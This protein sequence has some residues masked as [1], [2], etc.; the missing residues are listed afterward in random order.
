MQIKQQTNRVS[1]SAERRAA[2]GGGDR[3][4]FGQNVKVSEPRP[5]K[6]L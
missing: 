3:N 2:R 1:S 4:E 6:T 5:A